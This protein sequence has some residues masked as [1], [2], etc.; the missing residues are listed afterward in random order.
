MELMDA[1][2]SRRAVRDYLPEPVDP[3]QLRALVEAAI[4]APSA[5]N[6]QPWSFSIVTDEV[7]LHHI[8]DEAK[9]YML[10]STPV[11]LL[12]H[13]FEALRDPAFD[14]FYR[15]PALIVI[16]ATEDGPW[17]EIDCALAAQNLM[18]AAR[19]VGLGSCW[20]GF[21]QGW[22]N[23]AEGMA[24]L[25]LPDA[26]QPVAPIIIGRARS[27]PDAVPRNAPDIRWIGA[28]APPTSE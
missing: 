24:A 20:I 9:A 8:S 7:L 15:A 18:L 14:I 11:A 4:Q 1:I 12:A 13:H 19:E 10:R 2:K 27:W 26:W 25:S 23:S 3:Q 5:V 6:R 21:A 16:S 17:S 22:L 28:S